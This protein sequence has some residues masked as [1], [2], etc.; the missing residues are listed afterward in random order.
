MIGNS[1]YEMAIKSKAGADYYLKMLLG[2]IVTLIGVLLFPIIGAIS[3]VIVVIGVCIVGTFAQ[4]KNVEYEYTMTDGS[5]EIAAIY[6][7]SKRKE[8]YSFELDQVAMIVPEG[9]LRI[10]NE[11]FAK[12]RDYSS[13]KKDARVICFVVER[14]K[15]KQLVKLE[16]NEKALAHIKMYARNKMYDI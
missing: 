1:F 14:D 6:N 12:K 10:D 5:I 3:L 16:L 7:A 8:I 15:E 13:K 11:K 4:D 9:S 2:M